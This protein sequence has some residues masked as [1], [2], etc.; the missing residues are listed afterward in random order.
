MKNL[1]ILAL[2]V[3]IFTSTALTSTAQDLEAFKSQVLEDTQKISTNNTIIT[4]IKENNSKHANLTEADILKL[5]SSWRDEV[6]S[7]TYSIVENLLNN[8]AS[9]ELSKLNII[10]FATKILKRMQ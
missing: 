2:S 4:K 5:D 1:S 3:S 6:T 9:K 8:D 7:G 10:S